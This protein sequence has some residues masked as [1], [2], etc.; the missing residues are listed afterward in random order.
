[1]S[2]LTLM[3]GVCLAT[4][5]LNSSQALA[6]QSLPTIDVGGARARSVAPRDDSRTGAGNASRSAPGPVVAAQGPVAPRQ[7]VFDRP[8]G[9]AVTDFDRK[10]ITYI[11]QS[12]QANLGDLLRYSPGVTVTPLG[13]GGES[14]ISIRGSGNNPNARAVGRNFQLRDIVVLSDGF[15]VTFA[16]GFSRTAILDPHAFSGVEVYRGASSALLGNYALFG[17]IDFKSYTGQQLDGLEIGSEGGSFG[18][19][20]NFVRGGKRIVDA[21]LGEFDVS[22]FGSDNRNNGYVQHQNSE[23]QTVNLLARW[24]PTGAQRFTLKYMFNNNFGDQNGPFSLLQ[25]YTNPYQ[26]GYGCPTGAL[27]NSPYCVARTAP[28]NG[29]WGIP[30]QPLS[31]PNAVRPQSYESLGIHGHTQQHLAGGRY[32]HDFG[33]G[34]TVRVQGTFNLREILAGGQ[35]PPVGNFGAPVDLL[36]S[37]GSWDA[38][39]DLTHAGMIY[40]MPTL[41]YVG[42]IYNESKQ[43]D[44]QSARIPYY[45]NDGARGAWAGQ[46]AAHSRNLTLRARQEINFTDSL[47]GVVGFSTNWNNVWGD[48]RIN[49]YTVAGAWQ[50]PTIFSVS[51]AYWN[52]APEASLTWRYSPEWQFRTR[53][54]VGYSTPPFDSL[55][56]TPSGA[57]PN[58]NLKAQTD[59]SA[60]VG[61]QWTPNETFTANVAV[62][63]DWYRNENYAQTGPAP[64]LQTYVTNIPASIHRGVET[65]LDW[66]P[67]DGWRLYAAHTYA[68]NFF[69]NFQDS[70][71]GG[72]VYDRSGKRIPNVPAHTLT[73]RGGYDFPY[74]QFKGLG[75]YVDYVFRSASALDAYNIIWAPGYGVVNFNLHYNSDWGYGWAKNFSAYVEV[76]NIFDRTY[77]A[78]SYPIPDTVTRGIITPAP[79]QWAAGN[80]FPGQPRAIVAGMKLK[81]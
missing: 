4:I 3:R 53:Y 78:A 33:Q 69:T 77:M 74:G 38:R 23:T 81:F 21:A 16:D 22:I 66:R 59:M 51:N 27:I 75:A 2:R 46:V 54:A 7:S 71:T 35:P 45:Y 12:P 39:V 67:F 15:P 72:Y 26:Y 43:S 5:A 58:N 6:Q 37:T 42:F 13:Q 41:S 80:V 48:Y 1:M 44:K 61:A 60:E 19:V 28:R 18:Y 56:N 17:G 65:Q 68:S 76:R 24:A 55:T 50:P 10:F 29:I 40:G 32:E 49:R 8:P 9:Q 36:G 64:L 25:F 79:L 47:I 14:I 63:N 62:Y 52:T 34:T 70:L 57:G 31:N 30:N 20:N 11:Q 73:L